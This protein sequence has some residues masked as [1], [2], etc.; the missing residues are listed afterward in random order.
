MKER[1]RYGRQWKRMGGKKDGQWRAL[2]L[3]LHPLTV[4]DVKGRCAVSSVAGAD[5]VQFLV[6][7]IV[8]AIL[9]GIGCRR[10]RHGHGSATA[11]SAN[12]SRMVVMVVVV[13]MVMQ[14]ATHGRVVLVRR[15]VVMPLR[16]RQHGL[17]AD[18]N[19]KSRINNQSSLSQHYSFLTV[20]YLFRV[21]TS[22][23][24]RKYLFIYCSY[25]YI[26]LT[27][28]TC[29]PSRCVCICIELL[30]CGL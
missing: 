24:Y 3:A 13:V 1:E 28:W 29:R 16:R 26:S 17:P 8:N 14:A 5:D 12:A 22:T 21:Y 30:V 11:H 15:V 23:P 7:Q 27:F 20:I 18:A 25:F 19:A 10:A 9:T 4:R 2:C 6:V